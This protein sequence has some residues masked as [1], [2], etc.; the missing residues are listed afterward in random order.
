MAP[1]RIGCPPDG[2]YQGHENYVWV[3]I[4]WIRLAV[5]LKDV[6]QIMPR[7]SPDSSNKYFQASNAINKIPPCFSGS[8]LDKLSSLVDSSP[9]S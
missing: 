4:Q 8:R 1:Q 9:P 2:C 7:S 5:A 6:M 3:E